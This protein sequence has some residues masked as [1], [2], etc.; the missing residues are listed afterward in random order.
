[1]TP[2]AQAA[3]AV[4]C[5]D[6]V[7]AGQP[8]EQVLTTW[9]RGNRFA[10]SGDRAAIRDIVFDVLRMWRSTAWAGGGESGRARVIGWCRLTALAVDEVFSGIGHAPSVLTESEQAAGHKPD[11]APRAVRGRSRYRIR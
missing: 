5:L 11:T 10:G 1:M 4:E 3:A 8:A 9:A 6:R 2:A 7:L